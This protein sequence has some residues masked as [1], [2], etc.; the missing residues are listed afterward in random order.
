[1]SKF[2]QAVALLLTLVIVLSGSISFAAKTDNKLSDI[3]NHWAK[4]EIEYLL[5]KG[6]ISGYPDGRF[7]PDG[8]ITRAE[9]VKI[10]NSVFNFDETGKVN[11]KDVNKNDWF[12]E[13]VA[14]AIKAGYISGYTDGTFKPNQNITREEAAKVLGV[15]YEIDELEKSTVEFKDANKINSWAKGYVNALVEIGYLNGYADG[16]FRPQAPLTRAEAAKIIYSAIEGENE[17]VVNKEELVTRIQDILVELYGKDSIYT[18]ESWE[19]YSEAFKA[20]VAIRDNEE[21][22]QTEVNKALAELEGKYSALELSF[23]KNI[24][25]KTQGKVYDDIFSAI[26]DVK[27]GDTILL[28]EGTYELT[29]QLTITKPVTIKGVGEVVIKAAENFN[30][31][32]YNADKHLIAIVNVEGNVTLENLTVTGA[33][34]SGINVFESTSVQLKDI[35]SKDNL[36]AGLNVANSKVVAEN[37]KTSGN[38]WYGVNVDNGSAP[39][40]NAPKTEFTLISG[41]LSEDIQ[42]ISDKGDVKVTV[43]EGYIGY[44]IVGT[45]TYIWTNQIAIVD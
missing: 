10:I 35:T 8:K 2:R 7:N 42:I 19:A 33:K 34:R 30:E 44:K 15:V 12:Y 28:K 41:E 25:N 21:A 36:A 37:L 27:A 40:Q 22:R 29:K 23:E 26:E 38:A 1:M 32:T 18:K 3:A 5:G 6:I 45:E 31:G 4:K 17:E 39:S 9:F 24:V 11:F 14:K 43:P 13:E 20:A 16:T